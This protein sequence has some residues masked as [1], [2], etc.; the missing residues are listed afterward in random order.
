MPTDLFR[1]RGT[2][3]WVHR[4]CIQ[5]WID[6]KQKGNTLSEVQCPQCNTPYVIKFPKA[7]VLVRLL[8]AYDG[9]IQ[10]A[11]PVVAGAVLVGSLYWTCVSFGAVTV[12][13]LVGEREALALIELGNPIV[14]L[15]ALPLVP[16]WLVLGRMI[17]WE[18]PVWRFMRSA[19]PK[20]PLA[21]FVLPSFATCLPRNDYQQRRSLSHQDD[22]P[23]GDNDDE[24]NDG[25]I[26]L[27]P[28]S[29]VWV[30]TRAFCGAIILP[31]IAARLGSALYSRWLPSSLHCSLLGGATFV[32]AKGAL[33][34]YH[35]QHI[36]IRQRKRVIVDYNERP[37][38]ST[39]D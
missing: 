30:L 32:L 10:R 37:T 31:S 11:C 16:V 21:R 14:V 23:E 20:I 4:A 22:G 2:T 38:T 8:D 1:C 3:K 36:Y 34:V 19:V 17:P 35:M 6:E 15:A 7:N 39:S 5:R 28:V 26:A 18:E 12:M 9:Q 25:A 29:D 27:R 33:R 13:Q 24:A